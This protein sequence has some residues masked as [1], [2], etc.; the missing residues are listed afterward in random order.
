MILV[1][2]NLSTLYSNAYIDSSVATGSDDDQNEGVADTTGADD[3][4]VDEK[5]AQMSMHM[6]D[7][8]WTIILLSQKHPQ[9]MKSQKM[10]TYV[11]DV[12]RCTLRREIVDD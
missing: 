7:H 10:I 4:S 3:T 1:T 12:I 5:K 11:G 9:K 2:P 8:S 6:V